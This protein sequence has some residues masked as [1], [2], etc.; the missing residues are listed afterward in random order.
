MICINYFLYRKYIKTKVKNV[1]IVISK[2]DKPKTEIKVRDKQLYSFAVPFVILE[3]DN[4]YVADCDAL[5]LAS[6]GRDE[7]EAKSSIEA[8]ISTFLKE[9]LKM[10]TIDEVLKSHGWNKKTVNQPESTYEFIRPTGIV[11]IAEYMHKSEN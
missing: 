10:G 5:G 9:L 6:H 3:E 7:K 8:V 1:F 4:K 2:M 11:T